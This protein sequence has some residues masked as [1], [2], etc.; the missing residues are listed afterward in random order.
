MSQESARN[1]T[2]VIQCRIG[3]LNHW[4][5][6][7]I[8]GVVAVVI[9]LLLT[10]ST[11]D[12]LIYLKDT[13]REIKRELFHP[14]SN[15]CNCWGWAKPKPQAEALCGSLM[16]VT[17]VLSK[18]GPPSAAFTGVSAGCCMGSEATVDSNS[19][20]IN[21]VWFCSSLWLETALSSS[22]LFYCQSFAYLLLRTAYS[23][24]LCIRKRG[25][26]IYLFEW[27]GERE[28]EWRRVS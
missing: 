2:Q 24:T 25:L 22:F 4:A 7:L 28:R 9:I 1:S 8:V 16:W 3:Y 20:P 5:K 18:L 11:Q 13:Y 10:H 26:F 19:W 6:Y 15:G 27:Q 21:A 14:L 12:W 17:G 23:G